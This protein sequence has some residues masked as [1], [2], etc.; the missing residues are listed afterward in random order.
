MLKEQI[1][2]NET[3]YTA[4]QKQEFG[5]SGFCKNP[6]NIASFII[7][8]AQFKSHSDL[9]KK[10]SP[11]CRWSDELSHRG[12]HLLHFHKSLQIESRKMRMSYL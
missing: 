4:K 5:E 1:V 2:F 3:S 7:V 6:L 11:A 9:L 10:P 8:S 12:V